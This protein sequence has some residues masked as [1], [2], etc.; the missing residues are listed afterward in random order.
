[1]DLQ[2]PWSCTSVCTHHVLHIDEGVVDG[3]DLDALLE[4]GPQDQTPDAT[5]ATGTHRVRAS[6]RSHISVWSNQANLFSIFSTI[7]YTPLWP[8]K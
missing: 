6:E 4:A 8:P 2:T 1:M 7:M 3:H 5:K